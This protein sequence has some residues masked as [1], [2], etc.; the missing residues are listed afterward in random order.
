V[1]CQGV[2][3]WYRPRGPS[4]PE[5]IAARYVHFA[6][7]LFGDE[8]QTWRGWRGRELGVERLRERFGLAAPPAA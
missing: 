4:T 2:A 3:D 7:A 8:G 5:Q 6:L 1:L